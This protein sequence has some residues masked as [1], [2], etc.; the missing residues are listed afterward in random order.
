M[1]DRMTKDELI[2]RHGHRPC[3]E[4]LRLD[5]FVALFCEEG[6]GNKR[7]RDEGVVEEVYNTGVILALMVLMFATNRS[8]H[9]F[10]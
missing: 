8:T 9:V 5:D 1:T 6:G 3:N 2:K 7:T 4:V 10:P